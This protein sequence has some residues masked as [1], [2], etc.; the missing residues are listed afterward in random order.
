MSVYKLSN[1]LTLF[2]SLIMRHIPNCHQN[3]LKNILNLIYMSLF[4]SNRHT[5]WWFNLKI[6]FNLKFCLIFSTFSF[7]LGPQALMTTILRSLWNRS[8]EI[9]SRISAAFI[10]YGFEK[11]GIGIFWSNYI[12]IFSCLSSYLLI[13]I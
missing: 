4:Y 13:Y 11:T 3:H 7:L 2:I 6:P 10:I 1:S 12:F 9:I 8:L 5:N